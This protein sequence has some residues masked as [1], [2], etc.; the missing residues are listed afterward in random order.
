M[1]QIILISHWNTLDDNES[2]H[3]ELKNLMELKIKWLNL[4]NIFIFKISKI[5]SIFFMLYFVITIIYIYIIFLK[6]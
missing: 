4:L 1:I 3:I 2:V 5:S 6:N